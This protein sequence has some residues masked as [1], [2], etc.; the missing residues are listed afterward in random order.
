MWISVRTISRKICG[1]I[2]VSA[3]SPPAIG[4]SRGYL[5]HR[6]AEAEGISIQQYILQEKCHHAAN[7]LKFSDYSIA[8]ISEYFGFF[9]PPFS[10]KIL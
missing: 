9:C 10:P 5:S 4:I 3:I 7:L 2:S 6:F 1:K 8:L